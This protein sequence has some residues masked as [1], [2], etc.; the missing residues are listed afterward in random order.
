VEGQIAVENSG[1]AKGDGPR[2]RGKLSERGAHLI[3]DEWPEALKL[4]Y[5]I[6]VGGHIDAL[7]NSERKATEIIHPDHIELRLEEPS[8]TWARNERAAIEAAAIPGRKQRRPPKRE[9]AFGELIDLAEVE[10]RLQ[11][12]DLNPRRGAETESLI[13]AIQTICREAHL[14]SL[15]EWR[16]PEGSATE[17]AKALPM[18]KGGWRFDPVA[19]K[20]QELAPRAPHDH[21]QRMQFR[22]ELQKLRDAGN[23][24][25]ADQFEAL[26]LD[27]Q[28]QRRSDAGRPPPVAKSLA[29]QPPKVEVPSKETIREW[30]VALR[31]PR[32]G[33]KRVGRHTRLA[34]E[35]VG[36]RWGLSANAVLSKRLAQR[37]TCW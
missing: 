10:E 2:R 11:P 5:R 22:K 18:P 21:A 7:G 29:A 33:I 23:H 1:D 4:A 28:R 27:V 30:I 19:R 14:L 16:R 3:P 32:A 31:S 35:I 9:N 8:R 34:A 24:T 13:K 20:P 26:W 36:W 6:Y 25:L 17:P 12:I 15:A 37:R